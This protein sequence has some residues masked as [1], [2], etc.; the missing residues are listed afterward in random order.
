MK[1]SSQSFENFFSRFSTTDLYFHISWK[2]RAAIASE[3][4]S[5]NIA[6]KLEKYTNVYVKLPLSL[7]FQ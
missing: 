5:L 2:K 4:C 1:P 6:L 7:L 3:F